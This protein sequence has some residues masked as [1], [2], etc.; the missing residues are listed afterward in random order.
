MYMH[1]SMNVYAC[2]CVRVNM[3]T[4]VR[5]D[6]EAYIKT[7][8]GYIW[9]RS[10]T[11]KRSQVYLSLVHPPAPPSLYRPPPTHTLYCAST[12]SRA[13]KGYVCVRANACSCMTIHARV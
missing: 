5:T 11:S 10:R 4:E 8:T 9:R 3:W 7:N 13:S 12:R 2:A 6:I 1:V